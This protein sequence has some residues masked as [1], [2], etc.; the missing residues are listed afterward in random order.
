ME[1]SPR[2]LFACCSMV[3]RRYTV[4]LLWRFTFLSKLVCLIA[5]PLI[6]GTWMKPMEIWLF[7]RNQSVCDKA[8]ANAF[9]Q[10]KERFCDNWARDTNVVM[11]PLFLGTIG[12]AFFGIAEA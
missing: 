8:S 10:F 6:L 9:D 1:K 4:A 11:A 12:T 5:P 7:V 3:Q 2:Q